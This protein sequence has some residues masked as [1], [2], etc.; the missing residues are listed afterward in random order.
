MAAGSPG[1]AAG[2]PQTFVHDVGS[3]RGPAGAGDARCV[4]L[5]VLLC[6]TP[7]VPTGAAS[8]ATPSAR[9][10]ESTPGGL[11]VRYLPLPHDWVLTYRARIPESAQTERLIL[12]VEHR[13]PERASLRSGASVQRVV[14]AQLQIPAGRCQAAVP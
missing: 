2:A 14:Y 6:C 3:G 4:A 10:P 8:G 1:S 13:S 11:V 9:S 7:A 12:E 5:A